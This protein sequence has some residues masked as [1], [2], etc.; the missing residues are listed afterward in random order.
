MTDLSTTSNI[1]M[2]RF[3][4]IIFLL[5]AFVFSTSFVTYMWSDRNTPVSSI[6]LVVMLVY[7][8]SAMALSLWYMFETTANKEHQ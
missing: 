1:I 6:A 7:I 4:S 3:I 8:V 5:N 2:S